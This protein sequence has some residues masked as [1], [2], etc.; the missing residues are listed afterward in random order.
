MATKKIEPRKRKM[1]DDSLNNQQ[2]MFI[3]ELI[4]DPT[5]NL[6]EAARKC[7]YK[8][9]EDA[10]QRLISNRV[11]ATAVG[12]AIKERSD[13]LEWTADDILKRL[14]AV[15]EVDMTDLYDD[16]GFVTMRSIKELPPLVRQCITK[17][18]THRKSYINEDGEQ[19]W[20]NSFEIE[21]MS[22]DSAMNLAMRHFG[23]MEPDIQVNV[24][25]PEMKSRLMIEM[26][27]SLKQS[28]VPNMGVIDGSVISSLTTPPPQNAPE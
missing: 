2:Q 23:L 28:N 7:G 17:I 8:R 3:K 18:K 19:E 20:F 11:I 13:R 12:K 1:S 5:F 9:P 4:A 21:W 27:A 24:I 26:L 16:E 6:T 22:K 14:R 25:S 15:L 10:G